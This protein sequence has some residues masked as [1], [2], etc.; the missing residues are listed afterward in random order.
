[1][2]DACKRNNRPNGLLDRHEFFSTLGV[3]ITVNVT[4][5]IVGD[6]ETK[7]AGFLVEEI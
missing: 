2:G 1:M 7:T 4:D 5:L 3:D 6:I